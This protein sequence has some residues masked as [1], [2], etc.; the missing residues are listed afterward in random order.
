[1]I[2]HAYVNAWNEEQ[3]LPFFLRHYLTFCDHVFLYDH[4]ST[5]RSVEIAKSF[6]DDVTV[7][8][9]S[10]GGKIDERAYLKIHNE[11]YKD[12]S[13]GVAD[14][15]ISADIDEI[16]HAPGL[17]HTLETIKDAGEWQVIKAHGIDVVDGEIPADGGIQDANWRGLLSPIYSKPCIFRPSV[18]IQFAP[19]RHFREPERNGG[20][21]AIQTGTIPGL[22]LYHIKWTD[23][24]RVIARSAAWR[25]RLSDYNRQHGYGTDRDDVSDADMLAW[26]AEARKHAVTL[27]MR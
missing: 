20:M 25:E 19:G 23:D 6:G 16:I 15:V 8:T 12:L 4:E 13:R 27:T 18:D 11:E 26:L 14:W 10:N 3:L 1:M 24:Q 2:I 5:D 22:C 7:S 9:F 17:R 21:A